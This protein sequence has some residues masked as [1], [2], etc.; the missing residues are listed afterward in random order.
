MNFSRTL[1]LASV[2]LLSYV[3]VAQTPAT[4]REAYKNAF[5]VG[6]AINN[7]QITGQ[8]SSGDAII[9]R[10]FDSITPENVMKWERIHPQ[11]E[12]YDFALAD[13]YVEFGAKNHMFI[14]GHNLCWHSQTPDWVFQD[15]NGK[16]ISREALLKRLHDHIFTVV[17]R[18]KGRIQSW[19]VVNEALNEDGTL[20]HSK[21]FEIIGED[22]LVKAFQWAH[23]A[24]PQAELNYNDYNLENP[25][26]RQGA[27]VLIKKLKAAGVPIAVVGDQAHVRYDW[28]SAEQEDQTVKELAAAGVKVAITELDVDV[29]P[30]VDMGN[31]DVSLRVASNPKLNPFP[32]GLPDEMQKKLADQYAMLFRVYLNNRAVINRVTLW[33]LSDIDSWRNG[34]PVFG[35]TDDCLLFDRKNQPKPAFFAVLEEAKKA[36]L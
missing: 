31:A 23:E 14:V 6:V 29:L 34:W 16:P 28:P 11:P 2:S 1:L 18:Y 12:K 22:Y 9:A 26:K 35:R 3:A 30:A 20:R 25:A 15:A 8:D 7:A 24:D 32:N 33:G 10:Q 13:K 5:H 21:W 36:G 27:I 19:D 17:G 4:L